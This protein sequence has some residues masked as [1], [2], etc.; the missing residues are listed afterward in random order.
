MNTSSYITFLDWLIVPIYIL[1]IYLIASYIKN[2]Q[3]KNN[4]IYNYFVW[5][6]LAKIFGAIVISLIYVYYY[7]GG[8]ILGYQED[9]QIM[10]NLLFHSPLDFI[11]VLFTPMRREYLS[12]FTE[13]TGFPGYWYDASTFNA[14]R[15]MTPIEL[16]GMKYFLPSS[17]IMAVVSFSGVWKLYKM[18]CECYPKL[19]RQF[20]IS[21]L[22]IPSIIFWGSGFLKDALTISAAGWYSYSFYK[23]FIKKERITLNAITIVISILVIVLIKPYIFVGLLPGSLLWMIWNQLLKINNVFLRITLAPF[24]AGI[25]ISLGVLFWSLTSSNLGVFGDVNS[26]IQKAQGGYEDLKQDYYH[27]NSFDLGHY[28][29]TVSGVMSKF[30]IAVVTGLFRPFLWEAKNPVMII[31]GLENL[32]FLSYV[33]YFLIRRPVSFI[34]SLFTNPLV[35]FSIIFGMFFAFSVAISTSNFGA[36]VRLRIPAIPFFISGIVLVENLSKEK[37][38]KKKTISPGSNVKYIA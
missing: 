8:D 23:L 24:V 15:F 17:I 29:P 2:V 16:M 28:D 35:L 6:L 22:F 25:G 4:P 14:V 12:Y 34:H 30:P 9:S 19:Y 38:R 33:L 1:I 10:V 27:G 26:M 18:F 36:M 20:A 13:E 21:V 11:Q 32:I 31:S 37:E 7:K 3:I 5:G